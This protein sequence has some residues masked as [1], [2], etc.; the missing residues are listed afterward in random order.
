MNENHV[1]D[2]A[3]LDGYELRRIGHGSGGRLR[4]CR[5]RCIVTHLG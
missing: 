5:L 3:A 4:R 1:P 2:P